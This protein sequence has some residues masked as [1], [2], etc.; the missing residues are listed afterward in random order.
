MTRL[1]SAAVNATLE[2]LELKL[3]QFTRWSRSCK[4]ERRELE[5]GRQ[6]LFLDALPL[7]S[8]SRMCRMV[9]MAATEAEIRA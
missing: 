3:K 1:V 6:Q 4:A 8:G 9:E 7:R 2:K 5:R